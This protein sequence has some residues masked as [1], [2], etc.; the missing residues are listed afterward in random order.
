[1]WTPFWTFFPI[2]VQILSILSIEKRANRVILRLTAKR[3]SNY[4]KYKERIEVMSIDTSNGHPD[5]DY[6]EHEKTYAGFL[7]VSKYGTIVVLVIL[8]LMAAFLV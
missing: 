8:A 2:K 3:I 5:M 7:K 4:L 1:L 6:E